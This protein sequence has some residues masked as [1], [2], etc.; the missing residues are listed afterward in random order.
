MKVRKFG[1]FLLTISVMMIISGT[2]CS[3]VVS[4]KED[5]EKTQARM[6][7]VKDEFEAF[8][9]AVSTFELER[10]TLYTESLGN[11]YYDSLSTDDILLKN[12]FYK[13]IGCNNNGT[14]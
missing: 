2:V 6:L 1:V 14:I 11:I 12:K 9:N 8:N 7:V 4:L 13:Q 3:F 10:D 5:Q